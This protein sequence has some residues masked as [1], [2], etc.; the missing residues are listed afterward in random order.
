MSAIVKM[1]VDLITAP[2]ST[3]TIDR[4]PTRWRAAVQEELDKL[5][6]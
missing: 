3:F 4:V 5:N 6:P 2:G 1:Y